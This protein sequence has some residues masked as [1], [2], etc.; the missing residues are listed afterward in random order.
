MFK[1]LRKRSQNRW[2]ETEK[3]VRRVYG[4]FADR[5]LRESKDPSFLNPVLC[6]SLRDGVV[7]SRIEEFFKRPWSLTD[8][9]RGS[10]TEHYLATGVLERAGS[11]VKFARQGRDGSVSSASG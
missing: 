6:V 2:Q 10:L 8:P 4:P 5:I 3:R 9:E 7:V 11:E 1:S